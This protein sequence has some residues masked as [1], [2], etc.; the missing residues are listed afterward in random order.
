MTKIL[1]RTLSFNSRTVM[2]QTEHIKEGGLSE[3]RGDEKIGKG[4]HIAWKWGAGMADGHAAEISESKM[5]K[6]TKPGVE[7][8]RNGEEGNP[9]VFVERGG[10]DPVVK[11]Q[12]ELYKVHDE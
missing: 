11:K 9:A 6:E 3:H 5:T 7:I 10:K 8:T 1:E 4:D 2:S 12:S